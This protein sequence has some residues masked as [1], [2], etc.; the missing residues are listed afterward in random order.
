MCPGIRILLPLA[1]FGA[2]SCGQGAVLYVDGRT[3]GHGEENGEVRFLR[4]IQSGI[5]AARNGDVVIVKAGRYVE[6]ID[7]RGKAITVRSE[8]P[9]DSDIVASTVIDGA[10]RGSVVTFNSGEGRDSIITGFTIT[11]GS[12]DWGGGIHCGVQASPSIRRNSIRENMGLQNGGGVYCAYSPALT[13]NVIA[14]NHTNG[15]G[16]GI[17]ADFSSV[18]LIT[19]N[20]IVKNE[21]GT[22]GGGIYCGSFSA[23]PII[24]NTIADNLAGLSGGGL[25]CLLA[26]PQVWNCIL[27]GNRDDLFGWRVTYCCVEDVGDENEGEGNIHSNPLFVSQDLGDYH[28]LSSS[29]CVNKG[30]ATAPSLPAVDFD[31]EAIPFGSTAEIGADEFVDS[32]LDKLPDFWE[33][34]FAGSLVKLSGTDSA[35]DY[36]SDQ[37]SDAD[38]LLKGT[39]PVEQDTDGD[40]CFDGVEALAGTDALDPDSFFKLVGLSLSEPQVTL[41]WTTVAGRWYQAYLSDD[42]QTWTAVGQ[43]LRAT[44][45]HLQTTVTA[46]K[47]IS[48]RFFAVKVLPE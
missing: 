35:K 14:F 32:D 10:A 20:I 40:S 30:T 31:G 6:N 16:G 43:A 15:G 26:T 23:A 9:E 17:F 45:D 11:G 13:G 28:V 18:P 25:Y 27:W 24:N 22:S 7:F 36:D 41:R 33:M 2:C 21:A 3:S 34:K 46:A 4:S 47:A 44:G 1:F 5:D 12:A 37:L 19:S 39:N 48:I 29:P 38:E 8:D 42:L